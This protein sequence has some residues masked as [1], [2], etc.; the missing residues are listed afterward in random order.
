MEYLPTIPQHTQKYS[1][2][3]Q[4][5]IC[6]T[7]KTKFYT[8][9]CRAWPLYTNEI[10]LDITNR[11][12]LENSQPSHTGQEKSSREFEKYFELKEN[13]IIICQLHFKE[14]IWGWGG[15]WITKNGYIWLWVLRKCAGHQVGQP[16]ILGHGLKLLS[17]WS[18]FRETPTFLTGFQL[19]ELDDQTSGITCFT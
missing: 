15:G 2:F 4:H 5:S 18:F 3:E 6:W 11:K 19:T 16:G 9:L 7:K 14:I 17:R 13:K 12:Y 10:Y 8:E 1:F